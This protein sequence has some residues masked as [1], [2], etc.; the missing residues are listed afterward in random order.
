MAITATDIKISVRGKYLGQ[1]VQVV[2]WYRP[3]GAAFLTADP[4]DVGEAFWNDI[5]TLWRL[6]MY[7]TVDNVT[8]SILV[9][10]PGASGAYGE[11][12]IPAGEQQGNRSGS[13]TGNTMP[14]FVA[15]ASRLTVS[16]RATRPGQ[17]RIWGVH[18]DDSVNGV[19]QAG[20]KTAIGNLM[21]KFSGGITL[22]APVATGVLWAEIV[23]LDKAT[24]AILARQ[25]VKG[26]LVSDYVTTQNSR[27]YS[28]GS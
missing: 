25:D 24:G 12:P 27:K 22:G 26:F 13:P 6:C 19:L 7:P 8:Q 23:R 4:E 15:T 3:T 11:F 10:E 28:R 20:L 1:L 16:T 14:P 9:Q 18:E 5:K 17:K 2:Q 21:A